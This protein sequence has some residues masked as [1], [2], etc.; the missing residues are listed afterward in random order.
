MDARPGAAVHPPAP[1]PEGIEVESRGGLET[2]TDPILGRTR[3]AYQRHPGIR[4]EPAYD[5]SSG[6]QCSR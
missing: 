3:S 2:P 4:T 6:V 5:P 1:L